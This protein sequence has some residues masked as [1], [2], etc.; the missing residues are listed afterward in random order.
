MKYT[1]VASISELVLEVGISELQALACC[2]S[3]TLSYF[4][5]P[6]ND[7]WPLRSWIT[8]EIPAQK[9]E[10]IPDALRE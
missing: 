1:A 7:L 10:V 6:S 9:R 5:N 8:S 2:S 3:D 4:R